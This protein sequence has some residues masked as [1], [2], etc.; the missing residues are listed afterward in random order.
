M[1]DLFEHSKWI[2]EK[3]EDNTSRFLLGEHGNNPLVCIGVNPSTAT[4][5]KLDPT[6]QNVR[7]WAKRLSYDGWIMLNLYPQQATN[8]NKLHDK[9]DFYIHTL[10]SLAIR[11]LALEYKKLDIWEA[12][13]TLIE[14]RKFLKSCLFEFTGILNMHTDPTWITI[15]PLSQKGHPHHPLYLPKTAEVKPFGIK[16]YLEGLY[17]E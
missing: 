9:C 10:N 4:P 8:P 6:L 7:A 13:G 17:D 15:G 11:K 16:A 14:K 1:T 5:E 2:Y 12:W 3:N